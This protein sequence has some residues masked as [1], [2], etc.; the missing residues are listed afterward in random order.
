MSKKKSIS[1]QEKIKYIRRFDTVK[2][3]KLTPGLKSSIT[4]RYNKFKRLE[5]LSFIEADKSTRTKLD[6]AGVI[7]TNKGF[8]MGTHGETT[9]KVLKSGLLYSKVKSRVS[10]T[11]LM[12]QA[13]IIR[14]MIDPESY[15]ENVIKVEHRDLFKR[16]PEKTHRFFI[17][18][19]FRWGAGTL[20]F[21]MERLGYY[22][23]NMPDVIDSRTGATRL[24]ADDKKKQIA[25]AMIGIKLMFYKR[26]KNN[27][28]KNTKT[29][30]RRRRN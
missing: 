14:F 19:M 26:P 7:T 2:S 25:S 28:K 3:G 27:G 23:T 11:V 1:Y 30:R 17:R 29:K 20:D 13:Q 18:L 9:T 12:T 4:R 6:K 16:Y 10:Y 22:L 15:I 21:T 5:K 24:N 8:F